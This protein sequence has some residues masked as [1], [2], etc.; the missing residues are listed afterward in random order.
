[1]Y[2]PQYTEVPKGS[3]LHISGNDV[4]RFFVDNRGSK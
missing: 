4:G 3:S 1:M 2:S